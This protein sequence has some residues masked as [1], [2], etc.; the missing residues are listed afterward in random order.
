MIDLARARASEINAVDRVSA[1]PQPTPIDRVK[2]FLQGVGKLRSFDAIDKLVGTV[3]DPSVDLLLNLIGRHLDRRGATDIVQVLG[4]CLLVGAAGF[5]EQTPL[6][7]AD[8]HG[9]VAIVA[10]EIEDEAF[11]RRVHRMH[12]RVRSQRAVLLPHANSAFASRLAASFA[13]RW[14]CNTRWWTAFRSKTLSETR[15]PPGSREKDG[16][17]LPMNSS[18]KPASCKSRL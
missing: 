14:F 4:R 1:E 10:D 11:L 13:S 6:R 2:L 5:E 3:A 8:L 9:H 18:S 15:F 12:Q 16:V 7:T 17:K